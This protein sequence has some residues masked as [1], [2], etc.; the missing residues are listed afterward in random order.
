MRRYAQV[1]GAV[2]VPGGADRGRAH[3]G[4]AA[5]PPAT[6]T[7]LREALGGLKGPLM[8]VAQLIATIPDALP[9]E[10]AAELAQLQSNAPP[11]GKPFVRR[12]M[13]AELGPDWADRFA[14]FPLEAAA[15][16]SLGQVHK[17]VAARRP[18]ARLQAAIP[19]HRGGGRRRPLAAPADLQPLRPL[20]FD[21][22]TP[23]G[24]TRRSR[25]GCARSSTTSRRRSISASTATC[26]PARRTSTCPSGSRS[27]RPGA[28]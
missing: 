16:A 17:V 26:W 7:E 22:S 9:A 28:C 13:V 3:D 10:Y 15:A 14:S 4:P 19:E 12:R 8:K 1:G 2:G 20:G 24:S 18:D 5:R 11:M 23:A 21:A 27:C 25:P 6:P